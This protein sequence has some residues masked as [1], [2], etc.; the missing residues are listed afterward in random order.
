MNKYRPSLSRSAAKLWKMS[1]CGLCD[2]SV[3]VASDGI[4]FFPF[5]AFIPKQV[6]G[7][8]AS[9]NQQT[10]VCYDT[11]I[12]SLKSLFSNLKSRARKL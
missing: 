1:L 9:I 4:K 6:K 5:N 12:K 11:F 7:D 3:R 10:S 8:S 2:E